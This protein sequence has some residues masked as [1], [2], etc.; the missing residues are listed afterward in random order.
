MWGGAWAERG[1]LPRWA[2][3]KELIHLLVTV[4]LISSAVREQVLP[5]PAQPYLHVPPLSPDSRE[6]AGR[7]NGPPSKGLG[8]LNRGSQ[9]RKGTGEG[10]G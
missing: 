8:V 3:I 2:W 10:S 5:T 9:S 4:P 7:M 1:R 6:K